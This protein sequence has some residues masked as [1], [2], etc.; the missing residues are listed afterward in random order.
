MGDVIPFPPRSSLFRDASAWLR[1]G[2]RCAREGKLAEAEVAFALALVIDPGLCVAHRELTAVHRRR[3][4]ASDDDS[5]P[6]A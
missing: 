3:Q 1:Y 2:R 4:A 6:W 5:N